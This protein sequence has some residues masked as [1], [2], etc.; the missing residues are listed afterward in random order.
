M[1]PFSSVAMLEKFSLLKMASCSAVVFTA[2]RSIVV[3]D[4]SAGALDAVMRC[5]SAAVGRKRASGG[6]TARRWQ[7][8]H[9]LG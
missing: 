9:H 6:R 1:T 4:P 3:I 8:S 2:S 5:A 7:V